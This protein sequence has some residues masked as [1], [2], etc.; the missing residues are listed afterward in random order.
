MK[1]FSLRA[2]RFYLKLLI[3]SDAQ[4][5]TF[6]QY[7][8]SDKASLERFVVL[9]HDV[10]R[11]PEN[12]L[13]MANVEAELGVCATYYFRLSTLNRRVIKS[14]KELGHEVG[15]HYESL[16]DADGDFE[17]AYKL[18]VS[19]LKKFNGLTK[20]K[21]ISMHGRPLKPYDNR[22]LW[23]TVK[24]KKLLNEL[25]ILGEIYLCI[26]YKDIAYVN[27]TGRNWESNR[28]NRRDKVNS[29]VNADFIS[30]DELIDFFKSPHPQI[31]FQVHPERWS[32][33]NVEWTLQLLKDSVIN[34]AKIIL[35]FLGR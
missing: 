13:A 3:Q 21:T 24:G 12:A 9:R 16:S 20:V 18:F 8:Q 2:Y 26:D 25:G 23:K 10:D 27:D 17:E 19:G 15:F 30:Q 14:I 29:Q 22:D 5:L 7:I 32:D 11:K 1:D 34:S 35:T 6:E 33:S 31:V 4:F 28:S